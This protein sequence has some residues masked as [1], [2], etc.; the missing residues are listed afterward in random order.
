[1]SAFWSFVVSVAVILAFVLIGFGIRLAVKQAG[2][3]RLRGILMVVAGLVLLWNVYLY[4]TAPELP[5]RPAPEH[6]GPARSAPE[7]TADTDASLGQ[8][9]E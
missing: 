6:S 4:T 3:E 9:A 8:A 5:A 1:M 7:P 2:K